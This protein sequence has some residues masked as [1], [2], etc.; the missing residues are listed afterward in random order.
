MDIQALSHHDLASLPR[1]IALC[2]PTGVGKTALSIALARALNGEIVGSDSV[3]LYKELNIGSGKASAEELS[4]VPHHFID[5][6]QPDE[7]HNVGDY[8]LKA[9]QTIADILARG[10]NAI[11]VGGTGL[12]L[13]ILVHGLFEAPEPDEHIRAR[14]KQEVDAL[15]VEAMHARLAQVDEVLAARVHVN[16][17][18]RISRGLEIYEQTGRPLSELQ[19][20]HQFKAPHFHALKLALIRPRAQLH[21]RINQRVDQMIDA[22]FVDECR[23][24]FKTYGRDIKS[25]QS[26]G[27]RQ[28]APYIYG[29]STLDEAI[30]KMKSQTRRYAKQQIGW[31]R[32]EPG[33]RWVLA[34]V[35]NEH[36]QVPQDVIDDC[37]TFLA[38]ETPALNWANVDSNAQPLC[39]VE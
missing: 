7:D 35:L 1:V 30:E 27:Y 39:S 8:K 37:K 10:K 4:Q 18:V 17:F 16:D 13:R 34:P 14:L 9:R 15:G 29:E 6:L 24:L 26:L 11:I 38:G 5:V 22:G 28:L 2:G 31:L 3:Q 32:S 19:R 36:G 20:E 12:Y 25:L 23:A 21:E 33:V